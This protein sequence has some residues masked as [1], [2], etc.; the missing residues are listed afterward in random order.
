MDVIEAIKTRRSIRRYKNLPV[1]DRDLNTILD[2]ARW[3]PSWANT[4]CTRFIVVTD[5]E[6]KSKLADTLA[7]D[8]RGAF[9][10]K[11]A[12]VL[13]VACAEIG[14]SGYMKGEL[15]SDKGDW[16]MFDV[17]LAMQNLTLAAHAL[18]L[19]TLH[20]GWF[21]AQKAAGLVNVPE[22]VVVVEMTPL[23]YP[24]VEAKAG[25]RKGIEEIVFYES[26]GKRKGIISS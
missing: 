22:G 17:A 20:V 4:Q 19:G 23:G 1:S 25:L 3:A 26:Y 18:G 9:A 7:T 11:Q 15:G 8:N 24:D 14:K 6:K 12:P 5:L 13:I 16:F 2:A 21:D 10:I